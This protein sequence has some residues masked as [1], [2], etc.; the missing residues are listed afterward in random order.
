M[1]AELIN[2]VCAMVVILTGFVSSVP[3]E[4]VIFANELHLKGI[5]NGTHKS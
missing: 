1:E 2:W 3:H 4:Y 5:H